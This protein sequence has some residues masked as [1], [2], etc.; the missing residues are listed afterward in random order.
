[1]YV[2]NGYVFYALTYL[3]LFPDYTCPKGYPDK[4][5][6]AARCKDPV[7]VQI[8]WTSHRS[9]HNWV[10]TLSLECAESY[11]IGLLGS[12]YFAG[13]TVSC[14]F[15]PRLSDLYGRKWPVLISSIASVAIYTGLI[16][17]RNIN[18]SIALFFLLGLGCTGKSSTLYVYMLELV[19]SNRQTYVGTYMLFADGSTMILL[20]LYFRFI[21]NDW[22][23]FQ[24]YGVIATGVSTAACFIIPESPKF[25]VSYKKYQQAKDGIAFIAKFNRSYFVHQNY[26]F[27]AEVA[28]LMKS[29]TQIQ[30]TQVDMNLTA[31]KQTQEDEALSGSIKEL[32]RNRRHFINLL[33]VL[34]L[35]IVSSFDYF[36]INF[37]LKYIEGDI[38]INTIVSSVSE[39]TAYII[40]GALYET[41]GTKV[42]FVS[43]FCIAIVGSI[44]Y[45]I[46]G[47]TAKNLVPVM[48]LGSK[49]GVSAA[50]NLVYL[51]NTLFPP[52]YASTTMGFFNA[53]A[54]LASM[55]APQFAEFDRPIPMIIFCIMAGLA[56]VFSFFLRTQA[57][58][59]SQIQSKTQSP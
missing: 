11:K 8:D 22:F 38:Y 56:C 45:I 24:L 46:F 4:C 37:Q 58:K 34:L 39:V 27:E 7:N 15:V 59:N 20:S 23:W 17:S 54:R 2:S 33:I 10:E 47:T 51:A 55:L 44:F 29:Q 9:L 35:W 13:W 19:P 3:E 31:M 1:M 30:Q 14:I 40:S 42:S 36:L 43:S 28:D 53:F 57:S 12:M 21:S 6:Q 49:F 5:D 41:I 18:L 16:L 52:I 50:F 32:L 48:V 25:Y 26:K